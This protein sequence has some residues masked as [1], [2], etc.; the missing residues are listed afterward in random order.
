MSETIQITVIT[1]N[2]KQERQEIKVTHDSSMTLMT[3]LLKKKLISGNFCGGRGTCQRCRVQFMQAAPLPTSTERRAFT[4]DELRS[5][6][7]LACMAKPGNDCIIRLEFVQSQ[8]IEIIT[9]I[10]NVINVSEKMTVRVKRKQRENV[11]SLL[12]IWERLPSRCS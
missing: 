6:Y 8:E 12:L 7:R 2:E 9:E 5:G 1:E 11:I 4:P 10:S 3:T